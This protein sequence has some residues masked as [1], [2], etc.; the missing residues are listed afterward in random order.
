MATFHGKSCN[1]AS[2]GWKACKPA[3]TSGQ[4]TA[5]RHKLDSTVQARNL[6]AAGRSDSCPWQKASLRMP[7]QPT[8][9]SPHCIHCFMQVGT[10]LAP[11]S[12]L[13]R[14]A[15]GGTGLHALTLAR[16]VSAAAVAAPSPRAAASRPASSSCSASAPRMPTDM[17]CAA[18]HALVRHG[19]SLRRQPACG[20]PRAQAC[21][22]VLRLALRMRC[23]A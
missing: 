17:P 4:A 15:L 9:S 6:G 23:G 12:L 19:A 7:A 14:H 8:L 20:A 16:P 11:D 13:T 21:Q 18:P 5:A 22:T 10:P 2:L 1:L 3:A